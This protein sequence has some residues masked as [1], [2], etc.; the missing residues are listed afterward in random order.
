MG[1][2][3]LIVSCLERGLIEAIAAENDFAAGYLAIEAAVAA[4][5]GRSGPA[6]APVAFSI[7]RRETMYLPENQKLLFPFVR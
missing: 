6:A 4:A 2:T 5:T 3:S 1:S 7:V